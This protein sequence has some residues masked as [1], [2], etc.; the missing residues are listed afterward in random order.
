MKYAFIRDNQAKYPVCHLCE[1]FG[2]RSGS[3]YTWCKRP[4]YQRVQDNVNLG[5]T[6]TRCLTNTKAITAHRALP[7][8]Y[9]NR[10]SPAVKTGWRHG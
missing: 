5:G 2:G 1:L 10:I 8:N 6:T 7:L 9:V 3:Y 4:V